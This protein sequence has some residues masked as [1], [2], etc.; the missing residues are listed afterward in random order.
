MSTSETVYFK[1]SD[2]P[3]GEGEI[4]K[5]V[6]SQDNPWSGVD[7]SLSLSC[8]KCAKTWTLQGERLVDIETQNAHHKAY[9]D[10]EDAR[11]DLSK[12][13]APPVNNYFAALKL[14]AMTKELKA[15]TGLG[16]TGIDYNTYR[17]GR[18]A[19]RSIAELCTPWKNETWL[20]PLLDAAG[21]KASYLTKS[22]SIEVQ[23]RLLSEKSR[24]V[25][26]WTPPTPR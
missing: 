19:G 4:V 2:C 16:L 3:C 15:L 23:I 25:V 24:A 26:Y 22:A 18:N 20:L 5:S 8:P 12:L 14:G 10:L 1:H 17:K 6:T 9:R 13:I 11:K 21:I 7:V